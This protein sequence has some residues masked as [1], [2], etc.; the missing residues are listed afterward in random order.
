VKRKLDD[1]DSDVEIV[2]LPPVYWAETRR[3]LAC[4]VFL[5]PLLILYE[6][7]VLWI[8][9]ADAGSLRNGADSW[10][11]GWLDQAGLEFS[12]LLPA[13]V[14][15]GLLLWHLFGKHPWELRSETFVGMF[16]E[17][18]LF[19]FGLVVLGQMQDVLFRNWSLPPA[20]A[21]SPGAGQRVITFIGAGIYEE[22]LFRL[23]LLPAC[24]GLFR[25]I[26]IERRTSAVLAVIA[27]SLVFSLAHYVGPAAD[28]F[29]L[30]SFTF[31]GIAGLFFA[32]LFCLRGFGITVGCHAA[33]DLLVGVLLEVRG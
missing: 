27:T 24:Y 3:P 2:R 1:S 25:L 31:R 19:A 7:G 30:F 13:L 18:V 29:T 10:M 8:G 16:A 9:G 12:F 28:R 17:S 11:R 20:L 23:A 26:K 15:T 21:L 14:I 22:V 4:L 6:I 32:G 5:A 33:Y